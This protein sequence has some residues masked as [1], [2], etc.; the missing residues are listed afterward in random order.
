MSEQSF[1]VSNLMPLQKTM[2]QGGRE[3][4][5]FKFERF[6]NSVRSVLVLRNIVIGGRGGGENS[7]LLP[8][9][10]VELKSQ[11]KGYKI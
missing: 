2:K 4:G 5:M 10:V 6:E 3:C 7:L 11:K 1:C 8:R 9:R